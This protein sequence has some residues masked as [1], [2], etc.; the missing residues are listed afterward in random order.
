[1]RKNKNTFAD[2]RAMT[3]AAMFVAMSVVIGVF[4]KTFL[5]SVADCLE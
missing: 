2:V 1:M 5:I 3:L 4:C